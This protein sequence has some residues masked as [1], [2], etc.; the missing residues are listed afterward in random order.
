MELIYYCLGWLL[1]AFT[2]YSILKQYDLLLKPKKKVETKDLYP[3][4]K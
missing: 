4:K 1:G 3:D 2:M